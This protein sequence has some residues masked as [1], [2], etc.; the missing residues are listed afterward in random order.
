MSPTTA[1]HRLRFVLA[2]NASFSIA[3]GL[4]TLVAGSWVSRELGIDHLVLTRVVGASLVAFGIG[5]GVLARLNDE[6]LTAGALVVSIADALW[7]A[8]T[9]VV[10]AAGVTTRTGTVV[11]VAL[12]V[13][14]ADFG[15]AQYRLRAAVSGSAAGAPATAPSTAARR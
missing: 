12:G 9:V 6:Q 7:V 2:A 10:V 3:G 11:A 5:V 15:A 1:I 14:V 13:A 8:G 4:I